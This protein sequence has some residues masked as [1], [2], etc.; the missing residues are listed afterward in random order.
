MIRFTLPLSRLEDAQ[1]K[2]L[3]LDARITVINE[4]AGNVRGVQ[5]VSVVVEANQP[6]DQPIILGYA[7]VDGER[8]SFTKDWSW[9]EQNLNTFSFSVCDRCHVAH[10]RKKIYIIKLNGSIQQVGGDCA[11][12]L[13]CETR[14]TKLF[15]VV[16]S[17]DEL[18]DEYGWSE[19]QFEEVE[20]WLRTAVVLSRGRGY[21]SKK[22]ANEFLVA[23]T[24]DQVSL[25]I[26]GCLDPKV[27]QEARDDYSRFAK[28]HL[29]EEES[30][31][32][33]WTKKALDFL[34][35]QEF[36]EY[37]NN[38]K[39]A[40]TTGKPKLL[41]FVISVVGQLLREELKAKEYNKFIR[42]EVPA[43]GEKIQ[44]K[45]TITRI[46]EDETQWGTSLKITIND[47][48]YGKVWLRTTAAWAYKSEIDDKIE[49]VINVKEVL[50][51][52]IFTS[53]ASKVSVYKHIQVV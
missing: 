24:H 43:A 21:T 16:C 1:K 3:E 49:C 53:R 20:N 23:S 41:A 15:K 48:R 12:Q 45:G 51:N 44:V 5:L 31:D 34:A 11:D 35:G 32:G 6:E 13:N 33:Y 36:S 46:V 38:C 19:E 39:V 17:F 7:N 27:A 18:R 50:D 14:L 30:A 40:I 25:V 29:L 10:A 37:T 8:H 52:I 4:Y 22:R 42:T 47:E 2:A 26:R 28:L 9:T